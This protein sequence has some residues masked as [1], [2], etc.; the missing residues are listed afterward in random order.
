MALRDR[1]N[2]V[3]FDGQDL[4]Q[5]LIAFFQLFA[6][7]LDAVLRDFADMQQSVGAGMI[8]TKCAEVSEA[9]DSTEIG[10]ADLGGGREVSDDLE[11][12][13]RRRLVVRATLILPESSTSIFT[14]VRSMM[15]RIILPPGPM[16]SRILSTGI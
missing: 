12:L 7:V 11:G 9:G 14:P 2:A 13:G 6:D 5:N 4:Y 10:F 1:R 8:S 15:L 3:A 16:T